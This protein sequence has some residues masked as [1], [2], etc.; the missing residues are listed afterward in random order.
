M[1]RPTYLNAPR[2]MDMSVSKFEKKHCSQILISFFIIES[3]ISR[4]QSLKVTGSDL[5][6]EAVQHLLDVLKGVSAQVLSLSGLPPLSTLSM[7]SLP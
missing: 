7:Y 5:F 1:Q 6:Q 4:C 3:S 2:L